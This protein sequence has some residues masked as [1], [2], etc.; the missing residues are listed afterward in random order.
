MVEPETQNATPPG[1]SLR[2][3]ILED[4]PSD[5]ELMAEM[6]RQAGYS[7]SLEVTDSRAQFERRLEQG[8]V[9]V[10]LADYNLRTWTAIDALELVKKSAKDVPFVVVTGSLGDEAAVECIKQGAADYVLKDRLHRLPMAVDRALRDK[11]Q[12]QEAARLQELIWRAKREWEHTFDT[13]SDP[14]L[15]LDEQ[16][17]IKRANRATT[18]LLGLEFPRLIGQPCY[19]VVHGQAAPPPDCPFQR[20]LEIGKEERRDIEVPR[21]GKVF[22][23]T[24]TPHRDSG[25]EA[26]GCVEVLRDITERKRAEEALQRVNEMLQALIHASPV[27][28]VVVDPEGVVFLWNPAAERVFGWTA[29]EAVGEL[30]PLILADPSDELRALRGRVLAGESFTGVELRRQRKDGRLVDISFSAAPV[31]NADGK[32]MWIMEVLEDITERKRAAE[33]LRESEARY[34][35]LANSITDVFF[36]MDAELRYT[37]WNRASEALTGISAPDAL[38]KTLY[39][40]FPDTSETR[41]A[42]SV[43]RDVLRTGQPQTFVNEYHLGERHFL[44]EISVYS[45]RDGIAV[46][47][48]DITERR[49]LEEHLRQSQKMEAV[50]KL[51]GGVAHDFNNLLTAIMGYSELVLTHLREGDRVRKHVLEIKKAGESAASLARQLLAFSRRQVLVPQILDLNSVVSNTQKMLRRMIGED[52]ELETVLAT[53]LGCVRADLGQVEQVIMNLAVNARDAM[54]EGGKLTI[55]TANVELD[56]AYARSHIDVAPGRY[57]RLT[58]TDAG[59]GMDAETLSHIFE[60]FYT[61]KEEGKG[62]G[63]G[64]A[65]VYGIVKQSAGHIAVSSEPGRGSTFRIFLPRVEAAVEPV[66]PRRVAAGLRRGTETILLVED[67]VIV[68]DLVHEVLQGSGYT[69]LE[70]D[71]ASEALRIGEDYAPRPIHLLLTDVVMPEMDGPQLAEHLARLFPQMKVLYMSG[72]GETAAARPHRRPRGVPYLQKPFAPEILTRKVLEVLNSAPVEKG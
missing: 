25:Q 24:A 18:R 40:I 32:I 67:D 29:E 31:R 36:A 59:C 3:L 33:A 55:Q 61:T 52:I 60:P 14:V 42:E 50:G 63:L 72:Y 11:A 56:E 46:F 51:A 49:R 43:Y 7:L 37:Y 2:V 47:T 13:V 6:L 34:R 58:V 41:Q 30:N 10:I 70:A 26:Q 44:F 53:D 69:V 21:L 8:D 23:A 17:R 5:A 57:V 12:R 15:I 38:G 9:D 48:K 28:I 39:D 66:V 62:T 35:E 65:T 45:A 68:R 4:E 16:F 22:D 54:P 1:Q 64:L 20:V 19:Q 27:P 71:K